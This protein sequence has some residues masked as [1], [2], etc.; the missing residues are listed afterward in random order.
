[1]RKKKETDGGRNGKNKKEKQV[2]K[3]EENKGEVGCKRGAERNG[4]NGQYSQ[5]FLEQSNLLSWR[6]MVWG[7]NKIN[8][9]LNKY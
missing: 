4:A 7:I 2:G 5:C 6:G 8:W 3:E 1:M 9:N